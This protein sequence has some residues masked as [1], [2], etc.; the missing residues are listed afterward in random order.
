M[1]PSQLVKILA[2]LVAFAQDQPFTIQKV[3]A[4]ALAI[5]QILGYEKLSDEEVKMWTVTL[6]KCVAS[7]KITSDSPRS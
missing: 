5:A 7:Q 4:L 3:I 2:L 1:T 6:A